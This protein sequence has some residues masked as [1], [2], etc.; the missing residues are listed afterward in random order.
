MVLRFTQL[1]A[2]L[3]A[4]LA[5]STPTATAQDADPGQVTRHAVQAMQRVTQATVGEIRSTATRGIHL[6]QELDQNGASDE[7]LIAAARHTFRAIDRQA[8]HGARRV[9][10]IAAR[11]IAILREITDDRRFFRIVVQARAQ[12]REAIGQSRQRAHHAVQAALED[13]LGDG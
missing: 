7:E 6:I 4:A 2:V 1:L 11:T 12:S 5:V 3:I 8:M 13:A 10:M 9:N